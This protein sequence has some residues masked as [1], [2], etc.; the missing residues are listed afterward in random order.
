MMGG[1]F[2]DR[3]RVAATPDPGVLLRMW[4]ARALLTQEQLAEQTGLSV[5]TIRRF[6]CARGERR[7]QSAS[8]R[9]LADRL[10]LTQAERAELTAALAA[11]HSHTRGEQAIADPPVVRAASLTSNTVPRQLPAAP[12]RFI[13]RTREIA[14]IE[15]MIDP[16]VV[17]IIRVCG[18]PGVGKTALALIVAHR[19]AD[20]Y[21]DG[22]IYIDLHGYTRGVRPVE[23]AE[24]L[25]RVL[26]SLGVPG[27]HVP[28]GV[29]ERAALFRTRL[30]GRR[31]L[32]LLDNAR[33]EAH[34]TPLIPG[35]PGCLLLVT[36]RRR[37]APLDETS[38]LSLELLPLRDAVDVLAGTAG[39]KPVDDEQRERLA[40]AAELCERL[41]LALRIAA[42][43]LRSHPAWTVGHLVERLRSH[44]HPLTELEA[45]ER[46]VRAAL[47]LSH[48]E[49]SADEQQAYALLGL[50]PGSDIELEAAA[51]LIGVP[52][53]RARLILDNLLDAHL[54]QE[55]VS[56]RYRFHDLVRSHA[57]TSGM[58]TGVTADRSAP[59]HRLLDHYCHAATAAAGRAYPYEKV[60]RESSLGDARH[61]GDAAAWLDAELV[62]LLAA[63]RCAAE[64][65]APDRVVALSVALG[66]HLWVRGRY[67]DAAVLHEL[68][69]EAAQTVGDRAGEL[70]ALTALGRV[71]RLEGKQAEAA[72]LFA[73]AA[74]LARTIGDP[75]GEADALN[76]TGNVHLLHSRFRAAADDFGE[77][78]RIARGAGRRNKE[79]D[80]LFGLGCVQLAQG[81]AAPEA[82]ELALEIAHSTGHLS[83]RA[84]ALAGL[85]RCQRILRLYELAEESLTAA[86]RLARSIGARF[87][88]LD[89]LTGLGVLHLETG[90][91][92]RAMTHYQEA[93]ELARRIGALRYRFEALQGIG[94]VHQARGEPRDALPYHREALDIAT[95]LGQTAAQVRARYAVAA[96]T[97]RAANT[98]AAQVTSFSA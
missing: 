91:F 33:S 17:S 58:R 74:E 26:Q 57:T 82:F 55:P 21:P 64:H 31:I 22:Q 63:A 96:A 79:L 4:R 10:G 49:L 86:L 8:I 9:V 32:V 83:G 56:G 62:N 88:E 15:G 28:P 50:H 78:L 73:A 25:D 12:S 24:A 43:R 1:Q 40:E 5:R 84:R 36:T 46:S 80:A 6:E 16:S 66:R 77:A 92:V 30:A 47:E 94:L 72:A 59:L 3:T 69:R 93:L 61:A 34:F 48:A 38:S 35:T 89:A 37:L 45:G 18:M 52:L 76:G 42:A 41:P 71:R 87:G 19:R 27:D 81:R 29:D 85:G 65:G 11:A 98:S 53:P 14:D 20:D 44:D 75:E 13:G 60:D 68:A 97:H 90:S 70:M 23:P 39:V 51:A 2:E 95:E 7:P 67:A 54:L